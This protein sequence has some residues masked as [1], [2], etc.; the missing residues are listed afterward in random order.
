M[1]GPVILQESPSDL[2]SF[3][4]LRPS[5]GGLAFSFA[6][7]PWGH[8]DDAMSRLLMQQQTGLLY[9]WFDRLRD[10]DSL[11]LCRAALPQSLNQPALLRTRRITSKST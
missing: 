10:S 3:A 11:D 1:Y 7:L 2:F 5:A 4:S 8:E 6:S 9:T